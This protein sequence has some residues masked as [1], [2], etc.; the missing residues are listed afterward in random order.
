MVSGCSSALSGRRG[1]GEIRFMVGGRRPKADH[2]GFLGDEKGR[3][4]WS[5]VVPWVRLMILGRSQLQPSKHLGRAT[6]ESV[7][8]T[9]SKKHDMRPGAIALL[10]IKCCFECNSPIGGIAAAPKNMGC[11]FLVCVFRSECSDPAAR[12]G[13]RA[14]A[15]ILRIRIRHIRSFHAF[16]RD[17]QRIQ[18]RRNAQL[19]SASHAELH[20]ESEAF[21]IER[22]PAICNLNSNEGSKSGAIA[23]TAS[24]KGS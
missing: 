15:G 1:S 20:P 11:T 22:C 10:A 21:R 4:R 19:A 3:R 18:I 14:A 8:P 23:E 17:L 7:E 2:V 13:R 9:Q 6:R 16:G 12:S 5:K 24:A